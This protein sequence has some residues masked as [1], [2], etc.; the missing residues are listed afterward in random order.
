MTEDLRNPKLS[1]LACLTVT[2]RESANRLPLFFQKE[3]I[4]FQ[5]NYKLKVAERVKA[6]CVRASTLQPGARR[7]R[8]NQ[9]RMLHLLLSL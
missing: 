3:E 1:K 9:A 4:M 8:W 7:T 2:Q 6:K 5:F